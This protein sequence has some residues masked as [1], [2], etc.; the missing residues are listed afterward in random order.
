[1]TLSRSRHRLEL[2]D[3]LLMCVAGSFHGEIPRPAC[4]DENSHS[5][6]TDIQGPRHPRRGAERSSGLP[7]ITEHQPDDWGGTDCSGGGDRE[8][9]RRS[10]ELKAKTEGCHDLAC[11]EAQK[12]D[13]QLPRGK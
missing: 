9:W 4:P 7:I 12:T 11:I 13:T 3:D 6:W 8:P 10:P 5:R 2:A 1:M